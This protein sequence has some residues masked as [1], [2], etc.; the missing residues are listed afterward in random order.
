MKELLIRSEKENVEINVEKRQRKSGE[1][2]GYFA[3]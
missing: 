2:V 3:N 1:R